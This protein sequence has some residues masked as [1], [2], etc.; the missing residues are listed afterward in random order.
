MN[1]L[2]LKSI[3]AIVL[4]LANQFARGDYGEYRLVSQTTDS[5]SNTITVEVEAKLNTA[6]F[7]SLTILYDDDLERD[8]VRV[9]DFTV[10]GWK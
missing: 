5:E 9:F 7:R 10:R 4:A 2:S 6:R 3:R 1:D 8:P